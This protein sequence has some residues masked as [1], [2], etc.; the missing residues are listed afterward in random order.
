VVARFS[1]VR[2][3]KTVVF[4]EFEKPVI[5][6]FTMLFNQGM[7]QQSADIVKKFVFR[8]RNAI[9]IKQAL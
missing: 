4:P 6:N 3:L 7:H 8:F 2:A 5:V 9:L 1:P